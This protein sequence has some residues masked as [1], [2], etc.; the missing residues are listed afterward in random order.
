MPFPV[1]P[2]LVSP[3]VGNTVSISFVDQGRSNFEKS[4]IAGPVGSTGKLKERHKTE[5]RYVLLEKGPSITFRMQ[6]SYTYT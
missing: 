5:T 2:H 3:Y 6:R 1:G 4:I